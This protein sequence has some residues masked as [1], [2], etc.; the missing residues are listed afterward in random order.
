MAAHVLLIL[1]Q[2]QQPSQDTVHSSLRDIDKAE[3]MIKKLAPTEKTA[4]SCRLFLRQLRCALTQLGNYSILP[5]KLSSFPQQ[6]WKRPF[7]FSWIAS[8]QYQAD[9]IYLAFPPILKNG[10]HAPNLHDETGSNFSS[11]NS[12]VNENSPP[13]M[14]LGQFLLESDFDFLS[15]LIAAGNKGDASIGRNSFILAASQSTPSINGSGALAGGNQRRLDECFPGS[16]H[17][18]NMDSYISWIVSR[19]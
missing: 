5:R 14:E 13:G 19:N 1:R 8:W 12:I 17:G 3:S 18:P 11:L 9:H 16:L 7:W 6:L 15:D 2:G 4:R 10:T